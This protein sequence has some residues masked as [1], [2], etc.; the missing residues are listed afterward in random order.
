MTATKFALMTGLP[1]YDER[2]TPVNLNLDDI[3]TYKVGGYS[4]FSVVIKI[5]SSS[6]QVVDLICENT[7]DGVNLY[8]NK[9]INPTTKGWLNW[10]RAIFKVRNVNRL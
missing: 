4:V 1:E 3:I 8:I 10:T 2:A 5:E 6:I 9:K 7:I